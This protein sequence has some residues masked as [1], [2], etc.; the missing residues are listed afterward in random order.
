MNAS[1]L[2]KLDFPYEEPD[3]SRIEVVQTG[4][5]SRMVVNH[6]LGPLYIHNPR[7]T[8][9]G[10]HALLANYGGG[11][12]DGDAVSLE[13]LCREGARLSLGSVGSLQV[14]SSPAHGTVQRIHG[15]V[16]SKALVLSIADP[17]VLHCEAVYKQQQEWHL[18]PDANLVVAELII[19]G[20][21]ETGERFSFR[22]YAAEI[23]IYVAEELV[24]YDSFQFL[25]SSFNYTDPAI[26]AGRSC[27][28]CA[29]M[30]GPRWPRLAERL[31]ELLESSTSPESSSILAA[32]HPLEENGYILRAVAD[33]PRELTEFLDCICN[34]VEDPE[35]LGFN[36]RKRKY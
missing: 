11:L 27:L 26:F 25:P 17:V 12:V 18:A 14:Y 1:H 8:G 29:Y 15:I 30:I 24:L 34:F 20:R 36:P 7:I 22:E 33:R 3:R 2:I 21:L 9:P 10:C 13:I 16:E 5:V 32:V 19:G 31:A 35:F 23:S 28:L 4:G 6:S